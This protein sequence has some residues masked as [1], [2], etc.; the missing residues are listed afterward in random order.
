MG[1]F[2]KPISVAELEGLVFMTQTL[3][4]DWVGYPKD[5]FLQKMPG[6]WFGAIAED[7]GEYVLVRNEELYSRFEFRFIF[8]KQPDTPMSIL[9]VRGQ[10]DLQGLWILG[11][12]GQVGFS[13]LPPDGESITRSARKVGK[14]LQSRLGI[15]AISLH[16]RKGRA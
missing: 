1:L 14:M 4:R 12:S 10:E 11:D 16:N 9:I 15:Q 5:E 8:G 7:R 6:T 2:G 3:S 13:L